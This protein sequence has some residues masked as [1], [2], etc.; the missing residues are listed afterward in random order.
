MP[1][2]ITVHGHVCVWRPLQRAVTAPGV[3]LAEDTFAAWIV[4]RQVLRTLLNPRTLHADLVSR[5]TPLVL[6]CVQATK[7]LSALASSASSTGGDS[8][9][10]EAGSGDADAGVKAGAD[11]AAGGGDDTTTATSGEGGEAT[12]QEAGD[13]TTGDAA[14]QGADDA[15]GGGGGG[16]GE[17]DTT[18][19]GGGGDADAD[20]GKASEEGEGDGDGGDDGD[21]SSIRFGYRPGD[22]E[23]PVLP[24]DES[25]LDL[26]WAAATSIYADVS[27]MSQQLLVKV[28]DEL[29]RGLVTSLLRRM[30]DATER[31]HGVV[32]EVVQ[33]M[34]D[35]GINVHPAGAVDLS[36]R[37]LSGL[38]WHDGDGRA[39]M[40]EK[41]LRLFVGGLQCADGLALRRH[42]LAEGMR[43][44][45]DAAAQQQLLR[46]E[47]GRG[48]ASGAAGAASGD[49]SGTSPSAAAAAA[50]ASRGSPVPPRA[51]SESVVKL[52]A[53]RAAGRKVGRA[54]QL[55]ERILMT[56]ERYGDESRD[57]TIQGLEGK[58]VHA[59][60]RLHGCTGRGRGLTPSVPN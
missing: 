18:E 56:Y 36:L 37:M 30:A 9:D 14:A 1:W 52:D 48:S 8:S 33:R 13:G 45:D 28:A 40:D 20:G 17:D 49:A 46:R 44:L 19:G 43:I 29:P 23:P 24:F 16:G 22:V 2:L 39:G 58:C 6:H 27:A 51:R 47:A 10:K 55:V 54:L 35:A 34:A 50:D 3:W 41:A 25:S 60:G 38:L 15:S 21:D 26:I 4:D 7:S 12:G 5:T 32:L 31:H 59:A 57:D 42:Y 53:A 11:A